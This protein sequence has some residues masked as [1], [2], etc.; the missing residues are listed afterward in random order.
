VRFE[1]IV[2][3]C[4]KIKSPLN[5]ENGTLQIHGVRTSG[6]PTAFFE[7]PGAALEISAEGEL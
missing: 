3:I 2:E 4:G 5:I 1:R 7:N 6:L